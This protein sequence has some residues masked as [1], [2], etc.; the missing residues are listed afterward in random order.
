MTHSSETQQR[1]MH[2]VE[3]EWLAA[4]LDDP[5][6]RVVDMRGYVRT[7]TAPDGFQTAKYTGARDEYE[8]A[9]IPGAVY[10]DWTTDIV[11]PDDP[12]PAQVAPPERIARVLGAA[13]IGDDTLVVAYDHH[14]AS[15]FATRLWWVLKYYGHD[16]VRVLNGGWNRWIAEGRPVTSERTLV[17]PATFT[18][19]PRPELRAKAEDVL[20][21]IGHPE[22]TIIDARDEEQYTGAIRRGPRGGHIPGAVNLPREALVLPDGRFRSLEELR[23]IVE[24][25]GIRPTRR[26][27]AYC[28]GGVAATSVLF[29]LSM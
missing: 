8:Q 29:A 9:H 21:M 13:G 3:T 17:S 5:A 12:V 1:A 28:N 6:I 7:E 26:A 18:P 22:V 4:H 15:Q 25:A 10:L 23:E 20:A 14:P 2:L 16:Q 11:D 24:K 27:V 19:R